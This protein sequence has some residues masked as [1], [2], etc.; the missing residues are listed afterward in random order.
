MIGPLGY[1]HGCAKISKIHAAY[2]LKILVWDKNKY[3]T[4]SYSRKN[5]RNKHHIRGYGCLQSD[6]LT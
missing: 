1:Q 5:P 4:P 3:D 2:T 6:E